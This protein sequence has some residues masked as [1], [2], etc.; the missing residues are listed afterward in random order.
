MIDFVRLCYYSQSFAEYLRKHPML[1]PLKKEIKRT[2]GL[3][4]EIPVKLTTLNR[5]KL[6]T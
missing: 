3:K 1:I 4:V 6:T 2:F 5:S